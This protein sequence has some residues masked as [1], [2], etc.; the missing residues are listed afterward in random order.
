MRA[1]VAKTRIEKGCIALVPVT[2]HA[3]CLKRSDKAPK[4]TVDLS[5]VAGDGEIDLKFAANPI[6]KKGKDKES[7]EGQFI[8]PFWHVESTSDPEKANCE[9]AI[10]KVTVPGDRWRS[11]E[12]EVCVIKSC[13]VIVAGVHLAFFRPHNVPECPSLNAVMDGAKRQRLR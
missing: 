11:G 7:C 13:K 5:A 10:N 12:Y 8:A 4:I 1:V 9:L 3:Q 2:P 6:F